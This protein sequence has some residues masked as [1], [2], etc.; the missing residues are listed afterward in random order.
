[1]DF[2]KTDKERMNVRSNKKEK[3]TKAGSENT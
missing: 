3:R 1:M 2:M